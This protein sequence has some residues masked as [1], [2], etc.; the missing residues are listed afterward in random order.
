M[1]GLQTFCFNNGFDQC[2]L[3]NS[4]RSSKIL[5]LFDK[6]ADGAMANDG[7]AHEWTRVMMHD[8]PLRSCKEVLSFLFVSYSFMHYRQGAKRT[9][10]DRECDHLSLDPF[11]S[12][13]SRQC[14]LQVG[15]VHARSWLLR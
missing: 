1:L 10:P 3:G 6:R 15:P 12:R 11:F 9:T 8:L 7:R 2:P 14:A 5:G 13:Y 4:D